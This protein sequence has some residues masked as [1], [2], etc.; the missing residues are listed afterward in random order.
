V[1][2]ANASFSGS[3]A[4]DATRVYWAVDANASF[5]VRS[6]PIGGG[7][8]ATLASTPNEAPGGI[9]VDATSVYWTTVDPTTSAGM[10]MRVPI[11]GGTPTM[12]A[13]VTSPTLF[14]G[15]IAVDA[16]SIYAAIGPGTG[17]GSGMV[18]KV[19]IGG[20][21]QTT[22]A[23]GL[24]L[25]GLTSLAVD[26][27]HVYWTDGDAPGTVAKVAIAGGTPTTLAAAQY[28]PS[29]IALNASGVFW[30]NTPITSVGGTVRMVGYEGSPY[31]TLASGQAG[32]TSIAVDAV[33]VFWLAG[34]EGPAPRGRRGRRAATR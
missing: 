30:A 3:I 12:V 10:L 1:V 2:L 26:A 27:T 15:N 8:P 28:N 6:V 32:L 21:S 29:A 33:Y 20:G 9:A 18:V 13:T 19:P 11:Q 5:G 4:L 7:T 25:T 23:A 31:T 34:E 22:L 16:T 17:A 24:N 14:L